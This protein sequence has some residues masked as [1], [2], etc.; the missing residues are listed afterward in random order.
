MNIYGFKLLTYASN[1]VLRVFVGASANGA[2]Q[3]TSRH[4]R[5]GARGIVAMRHS[6]V[7]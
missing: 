2:W 1:M 4:R 7:M 5:H 6:R 3:V